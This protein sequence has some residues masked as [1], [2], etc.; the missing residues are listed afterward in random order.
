MCGER[1]RV[2]KNRCQELTEQYKQQ[3][4]GAWEQYQEKQAAIQAKLGSVIF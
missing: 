1:T 2:D 3:L 4:L